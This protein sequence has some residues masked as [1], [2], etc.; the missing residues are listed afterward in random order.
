MDALFVAY[1]RRLQQLVDEFDAALDGLPASALDWSPGPKINSL[2][3]LAAHSIGATRYWI[4]D[5]AAG[6][7]SGRVRESEFQ[8]TGVDAAELRQRLGTLM[9]YVRNVLSRLSLADLEQERFASMQN[10]SYSVAHCLLHAMAHFAEHVGH[11]Q[12]TRQ[13]WEQQSKRG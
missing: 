10:Q 2:A 4:G 7:S 12:V 3:V 9:E 6:E 1:E 8:T 5:V 11:A 13:L